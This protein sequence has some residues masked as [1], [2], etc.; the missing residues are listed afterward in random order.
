MPGLEVVFASAALGQ[1]GFNWG[2]GRVEEPIYQNSH[3][4]SPFLLSSQATEGATLG[5][6]PSRHSWPFSLALG[7]GSVPPVS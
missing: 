4:N 6:D 3:E 7:G 1:L 2:R 5:W